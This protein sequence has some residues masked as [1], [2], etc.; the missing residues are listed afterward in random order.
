MNP[1]S[2][3]RTEPFR[4]Y[5][6]AGGDLPVFSGE[7]SRQNGGRWNSPG[8]PVIYGAMTLALMLL[9]RLVHSSDEA[10]LGHRWV[11]CTVSAELSVEEVD[12]LSLPGWQRDSHK[13]SCQYGDRWLDERRSL[14]LIVPSVVMYRS[15]G[16][17]AGDLPDR[18]VLINPEHPEFD[19][20]LVSEE[21]PLSYDLRLFEE[22]GF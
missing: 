20:L 2:K 12:P 21:R 3:V 6:S 10:P 4:V 16:P 22:H 17:A 8:T 9:E 7:R 13:A 1:P 11:S 5:T 18:N 19:R 14:I 15:V